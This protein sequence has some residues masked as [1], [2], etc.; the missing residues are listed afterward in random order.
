MATLSANHRAQLMT[1]LMTVITDDAAMA[2]R[3]QQRGRELFALTL[4]SHPI[5]IRTP[6]QGGSS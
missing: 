2:L 3:R 5:W 4:S 1:T 6:P